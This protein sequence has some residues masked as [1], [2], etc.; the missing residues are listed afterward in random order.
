MSRSFQTFV[1]PYDFSE[2][3]RAALE[4]ATDLAQR[5]E[6][7]LH[8]VHVIQPPSLAYAAY[9]GPGTPAPAPVGVLELREI[10]ESALR[11]VAAEVEGQCARVHTHIVESASIP[12][13]IREVAEKV[14]A[15][16]IVMGTHGRTGLAHVFLG[17]VAE[18]TLRRSPCAV[19]TVQAPADG[20]PTS[21]G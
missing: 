13:A 16:L 2:H 17:S 10:A 15:D 21:D 6:S 14:S 20:E 4:M 11:D 9:G 12:D 7:D 5:F 3:S 18:R 19:L 8:L 1:V